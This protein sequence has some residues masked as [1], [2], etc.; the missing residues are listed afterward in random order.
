MS[1]SAQPARRRIGLDELDEMDA[2]AQDFA[3]KTNAPTT[4]TVAERAGEGTTAKVAPLKPQRSPSRRIH[5]ETPLEVIA[6]LKTAALKE[7]TT[8]TYVVL[9]ALRHAGFEIKEQDM[10]FY[11]R[12]PK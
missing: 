4:V 11:R 10:Q 6:Q 12:A 2:A 3:R 5:I 7:D 8:M 1:T 9:K